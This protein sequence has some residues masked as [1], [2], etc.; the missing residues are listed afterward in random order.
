MS[1]F[2]HYVNLDRCE[3]RFGSL[4]STFQFASVRQVLDAWK[5][6]AAAAAR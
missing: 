5:A 3:Q 1:R 2:R 6:H 4:L